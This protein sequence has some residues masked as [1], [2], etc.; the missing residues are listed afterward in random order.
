[1]TT[2]F[3]SLD[4]VDEISRE[5]TGHG[6]YINPA[7][8]QGEKRLRFFG[9]GITGHSAWT[10]E[11]KPIRWEQ[12]P[13]ELPSNI[14]PDMNGKVGTKR[15]LAGLVYDYDE[16]D[17]KI[18]ELTQ[19]TL[20]EQL[21]KFMKDTDYGDPTGYDIKIS[22]TGEGIKTEYSLVAAP[23]KPVSKEIVTASESVNCNLKALFDG[24]DPWADPS[25]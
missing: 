12:K 1:M 5:S 15:F 14:Q 8:L 23:P 10:S 22:K 20:M 13:A 6:R 17:F 11:G 21:F 7:K 9:A 24:D 19:R 2:A 16:Q 4:L 25:A 3:L 18:L